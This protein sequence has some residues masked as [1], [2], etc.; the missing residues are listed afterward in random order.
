MKFV[1]ET[2]S[3]SHTT[4][5][6][7]VQVKFVGGQYDGQFLY[8]QKQ[9][10]VKADWDKRNND[11]SKWVVTEYNLPEGTSVSVTGKGKTG[12]RGSIQHEFQRIYRLDSTAEVLEET[13]N[14]GL[15]EAKLKGRMAL[16]RD[17]VEGRTSINTEEG[18]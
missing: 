9:F 6:A 14:V 1:I 11:H 5:S 15:R 18:F 7:S 4:S 13:I 8:Q 2:G 16:V 17:L 10:Q 12:N 3:E